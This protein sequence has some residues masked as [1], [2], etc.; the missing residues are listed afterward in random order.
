MTWLFVLCW[1]T[2]CAAYADLPWARRYFLVEAAAGVRR[3]EYLAMGLY[4]IAKAVGFLNND[5]Q[6]VR[7]HSGQCMLLPELCAC[8]DC[9]FMFFNGNWSGAYVLKTCH[10]RRVSCQWAA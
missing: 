2:A 5:C 6:L 1:S 8:A 10:A 3:N 4:H 9:S 7:T